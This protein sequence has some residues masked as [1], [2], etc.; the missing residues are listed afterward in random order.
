MSFSFSIRILCNTLIFKNFNLLI[1]F[2]TFCSDESDMVRLEL[3]IDRTFS[4]IFFLD[5]FPGSLPFSFEC[6]SDSYYPYVCIN[7]I[8][9][10]NPA[11]LIFSPLI[12][13]TSPT[14]LPQST[15]PPHPTQ[16]PIHQA[17]PFK[18]FP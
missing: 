3:T 17:L 7:G 16:S 10:S 12:H 1:D 4:Y 18:P 8:T 9:C 11:P 2:R 15:P 13:D 5:G 6:L 14:P